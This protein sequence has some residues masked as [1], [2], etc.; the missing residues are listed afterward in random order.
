MPLHYLYR[1]F[2]RSNPNHAPDI[3][4][5]LYALQRTEKS[6]HILPKPHR[7]NARVWH[8]KKVGILG[9]AFNPPHPGHFHIAQEALRR[10]KLDCVW[11]MVSPQNPLKDTSG[12]DDFEQRLSLCD[13]FVRHPKMLTT[14]IERD[15]NTPYSYK[16]VVALK[17]HFP[18]TSF[19]WIAGMD[20]AALFHR[21][22]DWKALLNI[23]PFAFFNRP[24]ASLKIMRKRPSM[25][26]NVKQRTDKHRRSNFRKSKGQEIHWVYRTRALPFSSTEIR[27]RMR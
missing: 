17:R 2:P 10:F 18:K 8:G 9:G 27:K 12:P 24:P 26:R 13:S 7:L 1:L 21:W 15:L 3:Q 22:N 5:T 20:N 4:K 16:T 19:I 23:I 14:S 11:W 25:M 6:K